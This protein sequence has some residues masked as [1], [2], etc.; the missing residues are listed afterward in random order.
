MKTASS[1]YD[2]GSIYWLPALNRVPREHLYATVPIDPGCFDHPVVILWVNA[3]KTEAIILTVRADANLLALVQPPKLTTCRSPLLEVQT[4]NS[5]IPI[6]LA[7]GPNTSLYTPAILTPTT[8]LACS[9]K[10]T[11]GFGEIAM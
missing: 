3:Q 8:A 10:T 5:N 11:P 4:S 2:I 7:L 6:I 1:D 9:S